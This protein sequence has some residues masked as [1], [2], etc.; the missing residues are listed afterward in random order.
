VGDKPVRESGY[1]A[2]LYLSKGYFSLL[3]DG[4]VHIER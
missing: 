3:D 1:F 2:I 4:A